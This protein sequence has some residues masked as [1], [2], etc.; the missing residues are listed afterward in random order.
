MN[1]HSPPPSPV[2][3]IGRL[4]QAAREALTDQM[5]ERMAVTGGHALELLDRLNDEATSAA[6][7]GLIDR[8]TEMHKVGALD[9]ACD[10]VMLAHGA[11]SALTDSMVER[12]FAFVESMVT[13]IANE[14]VGT[15][16]H[17]ARLA[18]EEATAEQAKASPP[19]GGV[20]SMLSLISKPETQAGL[21]FLMKFAG[22]LQARTSRA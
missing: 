22:K 16:V 21:E 7:H 8:L 12:L 6:I 19:R 18:L 3:E 11:R 9:T 20:M 15:L 13:S 10:L 2:D 14:E 5:V 4:T 17:D 1:E